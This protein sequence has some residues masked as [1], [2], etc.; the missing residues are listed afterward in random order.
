MSFQE[1]PKTRPRRPKRL[2]RGSQ[3]APKRPQEAPKSIPA[4]PKWSKKGKNFENETGKLFKA[5]YGGVS[6]G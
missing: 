1:A 3:D 4:S 6:K 5:M 2:P